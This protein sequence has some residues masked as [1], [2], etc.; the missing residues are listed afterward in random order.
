MPFIFDLTNQYIQH[1]DA[2]TIILDVG[3]SLGNT[4]RLCVMNTKIVFYSSQI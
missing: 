4:S 3:C 2:I 1:G